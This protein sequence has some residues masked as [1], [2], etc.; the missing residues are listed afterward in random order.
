METDT[1]E[2]RIR[3]LEAPIYSQTSAKNGFRSSQNRV[4]FLFSNSSLKEKIESFWP[5]KLS[6]WRI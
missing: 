4:I 1:L 5:K 6:H 3:R 2:A